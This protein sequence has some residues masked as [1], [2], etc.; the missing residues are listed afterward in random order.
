MYESCR[1]GDAQG[2]C[3][4]S[5]KVAEKDPERYP[6]RVGR[7]STGLNATDNYKYL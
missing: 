4:E 3:K 5:P 7:K 2:D 6:V 1:D